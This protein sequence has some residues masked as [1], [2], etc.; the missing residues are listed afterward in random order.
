MLRSIV[1]FALMAN[2]VV[3]A[4]ALTITSVAIEGTN[5]AI[6]GTPGIGNQ[7]VKSGAIDFVSTSGDFLGFCV[8]V[9]HRLT[10]GAGQNA[11]YQ[12]TSLTS[13]FGGNSLSSTQI[14]EIAGLA[15]LGFN[16]TTSVTDRAAIQA[17]IWRIEVPS[18]NI[19]AYY[20]GFAPSV[21]TNADIQRFVDLAPTLVNTGVRVIRP[22]D[23]QSQAF[24]IAG[25]PDLNV[26]VL[27]LGGFG[28]VGAS[29]RRRNV[30]VVAS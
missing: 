5:R 16:R 9:Y 21:I 25:V 29:M 6:I 17:A 20:P 30:N 8:D 4:S 28:L 19:T 2:I 14:S 22:D 24:I 10:E 26:W 27:M 12:Y 18:K 1:T 15:S 11:V 3:P 7:T 13:D 23:S